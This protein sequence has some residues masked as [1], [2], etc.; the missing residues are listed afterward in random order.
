MM[1]FYDVAKPQSV[2]TREKLPPIQ[3]N[4][5]MGDVCTSCTGVLCQ[6]PPPWPQGEHEKQAE[7]PNGCDDI[8]SNDKKD[9]TASTFDVESTVGGD[10]SEEDGSQETQPNEND[11]NQ[12][13]KQS[14]SSNAADF[15]TVSISITLAS[16]FVMI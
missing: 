11:G 10:N 3:N 6:R 5:A 14:S 16:I 8:G 4:V 13:K 1:S 12:D 9:S 7:D 15:F 2:V